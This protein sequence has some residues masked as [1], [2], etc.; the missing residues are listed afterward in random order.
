MY[1]YLFLIS[2][3]KRN[4]IGHTDEHINMDVMLGEYDNAYRFFVAVVLYKQYIWLVCLFCPQ[5]QGNI[6]KARHY[7][8]PKR[9][10]KR[11]KK[12]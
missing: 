5:K 6:I 3:Y 9:I 11:K 2:V 10:D 12:K 4:E 1:S 7:R 8:I